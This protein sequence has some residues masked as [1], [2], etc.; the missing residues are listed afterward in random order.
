VRGGRR[1]RHRK[2]AQPRHSDASK[3]NSSAR[4][5]HSLVTSSTL[6]SASA[7]STQD[8]EQ[9]RRNDD[10][11][12]ARD[13]RLPSDQAGSFE[14]E[15]HLVD[16]WRTDPE[17]PLQVR[18]GRRSAEDARIGIDEGQILTLLWREAW[19]SGR[20]RHR[21]LVDRAL[22]GAGDSRSSS[23]SVRRWRSPSREARRR[24]IEAC[25]VDPDRE[26]AG[27]AS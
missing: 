11:D 12:A 23:S 16:G 13:P 15:H 18:F 24:S 9:F 4:Y 7:A 26:T 20:G 25:E 5:G 14:R 3:I 17:V 2:S 8:R 27:A 1:D 19:Y 6:R 10:F 22:R 21:Q